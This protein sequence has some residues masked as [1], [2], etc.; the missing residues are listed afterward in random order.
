MRIELPQ[1]PY[2]ASALEPWISARTVNLAA[3]RT[4]AYVAELPPNSTAWT[5]LHKIQRDEAHNCAVLIYLLL[6]A[7]VEPSMAVGDFYERGPRLC[8]WS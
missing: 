4:M 3:E 7:E 8:K 5:A 1:L 2:A 6:N